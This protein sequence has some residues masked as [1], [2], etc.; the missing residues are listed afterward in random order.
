MPD[1]T[2]ERATRLIRFAAWATGF[3]VVVWFALAWISS[4]IRVLRAQ[5]P[6][7][8]DPPDLFVS[9]AVLIVGFVGLLTFVRVQRHGPAEGNGA[10]SVAQSMVRVCLQGG[11]CANAVLPM[12]SCPALLFRLASVALSVDTGLEPDDRLVTNQPPQDVVADP[13]GHR[14]PRGD[15]VTTHPV[16]VKGGADLGYLQD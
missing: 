3:A 9:L 1:V 4:E 2:P 5:S 16:D 14:R 10:C 8:D 13:G 6:W 12:D 7:S 15:Q 11:P